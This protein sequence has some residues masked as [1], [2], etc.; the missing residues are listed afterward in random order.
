MHKRKEG[1][2]SSFQDKK[3]KALTEA[4]VQK[5][6]AG[7]QFIGIYPLAKDNTSRFI[8]AD[9]D[10]ENWAD[11]SRAFIKICMDHKIHAY[12]ERSRSG[13]GGHVWI[14]FETPYPAEKSRK[15]IIKLL[16]QAGI[17]SKFDKAS[18]FDRLFPNQDMLSGKGFGN[19]IALPFNKNAL[20]KGNCC[21][22]GPDTMLPFPDQVEVLKGIIK[23][24][25]EI[26]DSLWSKFAQN[27]GQIALGTTSSVITKPVF[28]LGTDVRIN[29]L[30]LPLSM[31][32]FLKNELNIANTAFYI[33]KNMGK[34]TH[35]TRRYFNLI[36]ENGNE[37]VIPRGFLGNMLRF[38]K[39]HKIEFEFS[40]DRKKSP[41]TDFA[42]QSSIQLHPHQQ[43]SIEATHKKD[44]GVIV[45]PPGSGKTIIGLKIIEEK[46]QPA[47]II[48]HR[49]QLADQWIERIQ[50]FLGIPRHQIGQITGGKAKPGKQITVAMIQSLGKEIEKPESL[51]W[52]SSFG[53][54]IVDEC[55]H[56]PAETYSKVISRLPAF[57]L[58][59]LTATPFR[60]YS[61][62]KLIFFYLGD[63]I[64][65]VKT[66]EVSNQE[67][68]T[69]IIRNTEL[70]VPFN[71]KTDRF[72]TL[73]KILVH[74]SNRNK[75]ILDDVIAEVNSGRKSV[76]ITERK[77]HM[78]AL[79]QFLKQKFE[80]ITLSGDDNEAATKAKWQSLRN[81]D[82]QVLI[83]TG[84][85]FGEGT[86]LK[87]AQSLFLAYPFSFEGKLI[88]YIG[89]IQRGEISPVVYD[90]RDIQIE[91][92]NRLFLKRNAYYRKLEHQ[93]TLFDDVGTA[94]T[95]NRT[96]IKFD[97]WIKVPIEEL[98]F[99]YGSVSFRYT[100]E[101]MN[102]ALEFEIE[103]DHIR[104]E[105]DVLKPYFIKVLKAKLI[106]IHIQ[107]EYHGG[108]LISQ[109]AWSNDLERI[110]KE[111]VD[112]V[113]FRFVEK[114]FFG[115]P[116][117]KDQ[118][119]MG[120]PD[121]QSENEKLFDSEEEFL[122]AILNNKRVKH[123]RQLR[124]LA[125]QH[126]SSIL[127]IR[128]VLDP[129]S[130]V[131]LMEGEEQYHIIMETLDTEE[132]TYI[133]HVDKSVSDLK[134][135][136]KEIDADLLA[137]RTEGRKSFL[138]KL[139]AN[140]TRVLHDYTDEMKGFII[141]KSALEEKIV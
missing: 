65:E 20:D 109:I 32:N 123:Y 130:F 136:L 26:L 24:P 31:I 42:K 61:D 82:Y 75:L 49:K 122:E 104:P 73:S 44:F 87:N 67:N 94:V 89:R 99:R 118:G 95:T 11:Q 71:S 131:F 78:D 54:V 117:S 115:N 58:Y 52:L 141:W 113:R 90:Y 37:L 36:G 98:E 86:D 30:S 53:T 1:T 2:L 15:I 12:L 105:L 34:N 38:C 76:I 70:N 128:F 47:I 127:K 60:K 14:F 93:A 135:R 83:T 27:S 55:H 51:E 102:T 133:W 77:E 9:F 3:Y 107:A 97:E 84:Q 88:Q 125:D 62:G 129:F 111:V 119:L 110:N 79:Y 57:Y 116:Q 22:I 80:V 124:Y 50:T 56:I 66:N 132:A 16:E 4:E 138:E 21:F 100:L 5:H 91:Y 96:T 126:E 69:I 72:E 63:V 106:N 39:E 43:H 48:V 23:T 101:K 120:L 140:F 64:S 13:N 121:I 134:R 7:E 139:P 74:D 81:G 41:P 18:S 28:R 103:N 46:S 6:L 59:G 10:E 108:R 112:T 114:R 40:D 33:R 137:I 17:F 8:A 29:K 68:A 25:Q 19:L 45:A 92:L 35:E 85:Y